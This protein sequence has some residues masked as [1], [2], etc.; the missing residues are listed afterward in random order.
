MAE[1]TL[2][3]AEEMR[4]DA[5]EAVYA[6][7]KDIKTSRIELYLN[8]ASLRLR[9]WV[10][11]E[12]YDDA[13][14]DADVSALTEAEQRK[15]RQRRKLLKA[16]EGDLTMSYLIVNLNSAVAPKGLLVETRAEGQTVER[17]MTPDQTRARAQ[18]F[19]EQACQLVQPYLLGGN[20]PDS[21]F[22][23]EEIEIV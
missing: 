21:E 4:N 12:I 14:S 15:I 2:I 22:V 18:E 6:L 1:D 20:I 9:S 16:A 23:I 17:Y 13:L 19:F 8:S 7:S 10:G 3:T 5:A 11:D